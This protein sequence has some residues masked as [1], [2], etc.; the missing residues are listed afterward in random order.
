MNIDLEHGFGDVSCGSMQLS[1]IDPDDSEFLDQLDAEIKL[2]EANV[3]EMNQ[4]FAKLQN[5]RSRSPRK[6]SPPPAPNKSLTKFLQASKKI[7][8]PPP[9]TQ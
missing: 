1:K 9:I 7:L 2:T 4:R 6:A 3:Q 5:S 8:A